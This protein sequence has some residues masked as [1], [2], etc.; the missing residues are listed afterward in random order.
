MKM[1]S[2]KWQR[3]GACVVGAI[4][5]TGAIVG[6]ERID[7]SAGPAGCPVPAIHVPGG[8]DGRGGC[9]PGLGNTGVPPSVRTTAYAGPETIT[10][11]NTVIDGALV[12]GSLAIRATGVVIRN[13]HINGTIDVDDGGTLLIEDSEVDGGSWKGTAV[14]WSGI[15]MRRVDLRGAVDTLWCF[16]CTIEDSYIHGQYAPNGEDSHNDGIQVSQT[17]NLTMRHNS[18]LCDANVTSVGGGCTAN[19]SLLADFG[20]IANVTIERNLLP[21]TRSGSY[22]TYAGYDAGKPYGNDPANVVYTDNVFGKGANGKC[23][24][25]GTVEGFLDANGNI[26]RNNT[27]TDGTSVSPTS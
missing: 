14:G 24:S 12:D 3:I 1:P 17:G 19:I 23:G 2:G 16:N 22:C 25:Y 18:V 6:F 9:W 26:W 5:V 15:T 10:A 4:V 8:S 27:F 21:A 11:A 13:S 20:H 7:R